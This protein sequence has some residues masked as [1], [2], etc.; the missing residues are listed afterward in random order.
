MIFATA[1]FLAASAA[2]PAL[3]GPAVSN[4]VRQS[5]YTVSACDLRGSQ[6]GSS[7]RERFNRADCRHGAFRHESDFA[8][9]SGA[10]DDQDAYSRSQRRTVTLDA[11]FFAGGLAGGVEQPGRQPIRGYHSRSVVF[12]T[13]SHAPISAGQAAAARGL[14]RS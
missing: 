11:T 10:Y 9:V 7:Q 8:Q 2:E 3:L 12:I 5:G 1:L 14:P 13:G 4:P 6:L